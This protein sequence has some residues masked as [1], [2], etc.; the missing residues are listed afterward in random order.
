M[1]IN[2][3][4]EYKEFYFLGL[5]LF[6]ALF[7]L[8]CFKIDVPVG[9]LD[10]EA[11]QVVIPTKCSQTI[12]KK[13]SQVSSV[14]PL[15]IVDDNNTR[16]NLDDDIVSYTTSSFSIKLPYNLNYYTDKFGADKSTHQLIVAQTQVFEHIIQMQLLKRP[17]T[18]ESFEQMIHY[19]LLVSEIENKIYAYINNPADKQL[20]EQSIYR[21]LKQI[22]PKE[23]KILA[24]IKIKQDEIVRDLEGSD[25]P[26]AYEA[27]V[28]V[29][30]INE[31]IHLMASRTHSDFYTKVF[32]KGFDYRQFNK[33]VI[34]NIIER[35][36]REL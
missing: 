18:V 27:I 22:D 20:D 5:L 21:K 36:D 24:A 10:I 29:V 16:C 26:S 15:E 34:F 11:N 33:P 3:A 32:N 23:S 17:A 8:F 28:F 14:P 1:K 4:T 6:L 25:N 31:H 13:F 30:I 19:S 9:A 7:Y 35:I 2:N 12:Y